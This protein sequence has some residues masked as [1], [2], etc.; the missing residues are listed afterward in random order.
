M[1]S[2]ID[3]EKHE[4]AGN[5][6][7]VAGGPL[8]VIGPNNFDLTVLSLGARPYKED[9]L[10]HIKYFPKTDKYDFRIYRAGKRCR[11]KQ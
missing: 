7:L 11:S 10:I 6:Q 8:P 9:Y 2:K 4:K 1:A 3:M 5:L